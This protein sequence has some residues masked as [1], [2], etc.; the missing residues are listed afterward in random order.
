[1]NEVSVCMYIEQVRIPEVPALGPRLMN[2]YV[3]PMVEG[4]ENYKL[5]LKHQPALT[6]PVHHVRYLP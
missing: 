1:M 6:L 5:L 4:T 2:L 3:Q